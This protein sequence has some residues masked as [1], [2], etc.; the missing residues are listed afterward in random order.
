ML[1]EAYGHFAEE[2]QAFDE[3][4][5]LPKSEDYFSD[6]SDIFEERTEER[7]VIALCL[8]D[9]TAPPHHGNKRRRSADCSPS[10]SPKDNAFGEKIIRISGSQDKTNTGKCFL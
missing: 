3:D 4:K 2:M 8:E 9:A 1:A 7:E 10:P 6:D 5:A